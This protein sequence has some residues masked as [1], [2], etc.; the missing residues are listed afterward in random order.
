MMDLSEYFLDYWN[1]AKLLW[2]LFQ[3]NEVIMTIIESLFLLIFLIV[4]SPL[5]FLAWVIINTIEDAKKA[6]SSL[7][8][9]IRKLTLKLKLTFN[10]L[11]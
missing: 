4:I 8:G 6:Y 2:I 11:T 5:L 9:A 1:D 7:R 10:R 3:L